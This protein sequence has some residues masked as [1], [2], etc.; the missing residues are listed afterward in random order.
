MLQGAL[1]YFRS[2]GFPG[3]IRNLQRYD[4]ASYAIGKSIIDG[5]MA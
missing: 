5:L 1:D 3:V 4:I 2:G